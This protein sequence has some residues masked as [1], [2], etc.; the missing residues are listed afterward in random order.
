MKKTILI[1]DDQAEF[2]YLIKF[3]LE[4]S[5]YDTIEAS[6]IIAGLEL[7]KSQEVDLA[8]I[9]ISI[10]ESFDGLTMCRALKN[11]PLTAAIA[12]IIISGNDSASAYLDASQA[13]CDKFLPKPFSILKLIESV[14][15]LLAKQ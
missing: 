1:V 8:I 10:S 4:Y 11:N 9:D 15:Q 2:R 5:G 13:G 12:I 14:E 7:I 3:N 6:D